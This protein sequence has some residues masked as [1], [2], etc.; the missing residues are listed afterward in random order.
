MAGERRC[1]LPASNYIAALIGR[2]HFVSWFR[3][4]RALR[5]RNYRLFLTGQ[6]ISLIGTWMQQTG[7]MWLVN[8]IAA[9]PSQADA[10]G[11]WSHT[12]GL[13]WLTGPAAM[14]G[15][16][17]F[18]S[19]IPT[20]FVAPWAGVMADRWNRHRALLITQTLA[21]TQAVVLAALTFNG[22]I[23]VWQILAL[24]ACL[25]IINGFDMPLRQSFVVE[26]VPDRQDLPNAIAVNS[27]IVNAAR[28]IGPALAG[29]LIALGGEK[30]CFLL[31]A[32][33]YGPVLMSLLLM[34]DLPKWQRRTHPA[35]LHGLKEGLRYAFGFP[36]I[37]SLL[38]LMGVVSLCS[39]P[40]SVLLPLFTTQIL[41]GDALMYGLL[42]A[43]SGVGALTSAVQLASRRHIL[44]MARHLTAAAIVLGLGLVAFS[45]SRMIWL[46]VAL[47]LVTGFCLMF[48]LAATNTLLQTLV[49]EDKRGRVMS[50]YATA[51]IGAAPWGSLLGGAV[52]Q[53]VGAPRVVRF[54]GWVCVI[55]ALIFTAYLPRLRTHIRPIYRRLGILPPIAEAL[56]A[57]AELTTPPE[58]AG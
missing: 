47:L 6:S 24:A 12:A 44:G 31:N 30:T 13:G 25:G 8:R 33:S 40:L 4:P 35:V 16:V 2:L 42:V 37:R 52:A 22:S 19:Q 17:G 1:E 9:S 11:R 45:Y 32:L 43:A 21:M 20:F 3:V 26:M 5:H 49:D 54:G 36:P 14:L 18:C 53:R 39:M 51:F 57:T 46:S 23:T 10:I 29:L 48:Q 41:H 28:L 50:L 55:A 7:M 38:L 34:R 56:Q 15:L 58:E 27:S